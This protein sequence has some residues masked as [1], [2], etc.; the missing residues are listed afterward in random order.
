MHVIVI[1]F[2][3]LLIAIYCYLKML[4]IR[5]GSEGLLWRNKHDYVQKLFSIAIKRGVLW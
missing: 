4:P 5:V 1:N 3:E 2:F